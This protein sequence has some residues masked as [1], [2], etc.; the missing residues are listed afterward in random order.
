MKEKKKFKINSQNPSQ[1]SSSSS[2]ITS[3]AFLLRWDYAYENSYLN[4]C[5][6]LLSLSFKRVCIS[7]SLSSF[8]YFIFDL[9]NNI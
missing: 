8:F 9:I 3:F 2:W 6:T 7:K 5:L 4:F 1:Q